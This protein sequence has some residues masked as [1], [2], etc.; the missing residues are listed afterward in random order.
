[1]FHNILSQIIVGIDQWTAS[2]P[3]PKNAKKINF[4]RRTYAV[5]LLATFLV[6]R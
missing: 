6:V 3:L 2:V 4:F 1:M 5:I